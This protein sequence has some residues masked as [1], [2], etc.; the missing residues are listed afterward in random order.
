MHARL[1]QRTRIRSECPKT[2]LVT[3]DECAIV[4]HPA[5]VNR[6][7][8]LQVVVEYGRRADAARERDGELSYNTG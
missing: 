3:K 4:K 7:A 6:S 8:A 5:G 1:A 2:H